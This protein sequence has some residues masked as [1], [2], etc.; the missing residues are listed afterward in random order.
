MIFECQTEYKTIFI[1]H[2]G[3]T[4]CKMH[5]SDREILAFELF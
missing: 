4:R 2:I 3:N 1:E 5:L